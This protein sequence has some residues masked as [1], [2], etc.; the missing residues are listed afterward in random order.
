MYKLSRPRTPYVTFFVLY[1][2]VRN[3]RGVSTGSDNFSS[4]N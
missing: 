2:R 3:V 1:L 4:L